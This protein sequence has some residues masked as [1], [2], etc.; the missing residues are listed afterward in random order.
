MKPCIYAKV[1]GGF[2]G[3]QDALYEVVLGGVV[4]SCISTQIRMTQG[5]TDSTTYI[6]A[7][8]LS[9][10]RKSLISTIETGKLLRFSVFRRMH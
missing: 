8:I 5:D 1:L 6:L 3:R 10:N 9:P 7:L 2:A 4:E